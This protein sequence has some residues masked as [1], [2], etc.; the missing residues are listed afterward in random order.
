MIEAGKRNDMITQI[1][2]IQTV[3][4]ALACIAAGADRIGVLVGEPGGKFPCAVSEERCSE[5]YQAV[6]N[7]AVRVL[8][9]VKDNPEDILKETELLRPDVL[10]LCANYDGNPAFRRELKER[11]PGVLLME[12]VGVEDETA[13]A[14]AER[15]S[16]F[17]DILILDSVSKTVPGVGAAGVT[18]DWSIDERIV[19]KV[20]VPVI[21]AG[22]LGVDNVAQAIEKVHPAGVDSLT[23]TSVKKDGVILH[24]DIDLVRRF[25][26]IAH[27]Y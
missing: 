18:H 7:H 6:G 8:I 1:Y 23:K 21:L 19:R 12:A 3:E 27:Q 2:S 22:G 25:C 26:A 14:E 4:E 16:E 11:I 5:I 17:A 10:H 13:I 20:N 24:K 9:S 15:K